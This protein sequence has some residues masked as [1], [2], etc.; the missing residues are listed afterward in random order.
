MLAELSAGP[1]D[2][3]NNG[4]GS[5]RGAESAKQQLRRLLPGRAGL[6]AVVAASAVVAADLTSTI[7]Y[8]IWVCMYDLTGQHMLRCGVSA[9]CEL[10]LH[11]MQ[12]ICSQQYSRGSVPVVCILLG[13]CAS[14]LSG[15]VAGRQL[16]GVLQQII[17]RCI[18]PTAHE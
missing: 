9:W 6:T 17:A 5:M 10:L 13:A 16:T 1:R 18:K 3:V 12:N 14:G 4:G 2:A 11:G 8:S 15:L 7:T